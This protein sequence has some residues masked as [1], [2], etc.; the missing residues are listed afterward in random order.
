MSSPWCHRVL[1]GCPLT[2]LGTYPGEQKGI[3]PCGEWRI[4]A[5]VGCALQLSPLITCLCAISGCNL[6]LIATVAG[7]AGGMQGWDGDSSTKGVK[8]IQV[9]GEWSEKVLGWAKDQNIQAFHQLRC[10][11]VA[12]Q[13]WEGS[14]WG[15]KTPW[16][17]QQSTLPRDTPGNRCAGPQGIEREGKMRFICVPVLLKNIILWISNTKEKEEKQSWNIFPKLT[18]VNHFPD[19]SLGFQPWSSLTNTSILFQVIWERRFLHIS[20]D[21]EQCRWK[22][23][24]LS[25]SPPEGHYNHSPFQLLGQSRGRTSRFLL[26]GSS[27]HK[28]GSKL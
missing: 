21:L 16:N 4:S 20:P 2:S 14:C 9:E 8:G 11:L 17:G 28:W 10:Q 18:W 25:V 15:G 3:T 5:R 13:G 19:T 12:G 24:S 26:L 22:Y 7:W 23:F 27:L 1:F 6:H